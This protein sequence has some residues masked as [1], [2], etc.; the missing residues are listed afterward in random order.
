MSLRAASGSEPTSPAFEEQCAAR[1]R[2]Y[3]AEDVQQR[4]LSAARRSPDGHVIRGFDLKRDVAHRGYR[5]SGHRK[6][7]GDVASV[8]NHPITSALSV[9][10]IGS[11]ATVHI[12]Y[13]A[14]TAIVT[15]SSAMYTISAR[16]SNTKK[17]KFAGIPGIA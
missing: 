4:R 14:A 6:H 11:R 8:D 12:G 7:F 17:R 2:I 5:T 10:E 9:A 3:T 1:R 13:T 16:G 15:A